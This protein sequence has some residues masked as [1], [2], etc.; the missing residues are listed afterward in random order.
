MY[1]AVATLIWHK[2]RALERIALDG[3]LSDAI[4]RMI[5]VLNGWMTAYLLWYVVTVAGGGTIL[6]AVLARKGMGPW[7]WSS[8]V[9]W[10]VFLVWNWTAGRAYVRREFGHHRDA[11]VQVLRDLEDA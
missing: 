4:R 11:L 5:A 6:L 10:A 9:C 7:W 3:T 2:A 1:C 8:S